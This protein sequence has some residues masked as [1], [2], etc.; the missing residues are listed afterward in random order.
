LDWACSTDAGEKKLRKILSREGG[1]GLEGVRT[2]RSPRRGWE[3][4]IKMNLIG[5][6][7]KWF[8]VRTSA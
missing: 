7:L 4:N 2:L 1:G 8:R 6:G 3:N 5:T